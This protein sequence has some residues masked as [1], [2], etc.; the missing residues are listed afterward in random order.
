[1]M[2]AWRSQLPARYA[3]NENGVDWDA[4]SAL[5]DGRKIFIEYPLPEKGANA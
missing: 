4:V 1:M 3:S 5:P 2:V